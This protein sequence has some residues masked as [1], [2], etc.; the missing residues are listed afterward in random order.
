MRPRTEA[1][2]L[3]PT[4]RRSPSALGALEGGEVAGVEDVEA[5]V[6]EDD[7][8]AAAAGLGQPAAGGLAGQDLVRQPLPGD[9]QL[10]GVD[11]VGPGVADGDPGGDVG[12]PARLGQVAARA[13]AGGQHGDDRV[14]GA[15]HVGHVADL[16]RD[17]GDPLRGGEGHP[18]GPAGDQHGVELEGR[19]HLGGGAGRPPRRRAAGRRRPARPP[20]G[21]G[22]RWWRGRR[23]RSRASWGRRR[24]GCP[25]DGSASMTARAT[26]GRDH[27]LLV[28][29]QHDRAP[30][31]R[32]GAGSAPA[33]PRRRRRRRPDRRRGPGAGAAAGCRRGSGSC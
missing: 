22:S 23:R 16:R 9:G 28:V 27:P 21:W 15:G 3:R 2:E 10:V 33:G 32:S 24:R 20:A 8:A 11:D 25:A 14:A 4:T 6:G 13:Q 19:P 18:L 26:A 5:A 12:Q 1:S 31:R 30:A 7:L 17:V 29:G